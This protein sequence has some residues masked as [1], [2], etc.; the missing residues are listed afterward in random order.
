LHWKRWNELVKDMVKEN[1]EAVYK[2]GRVILPPE[3]RDTI[4]SEIKDYP[5]L[6]KYE[7]HKKLDVIG[8]YVDSE[9]RKYYS[10]P[11][12]IPCVYLCGDNSEVHRWGVELEENDFFK[13]VDKLRELSAQKAIYHTVVGVK[14][15][16]LHRLHKIYNLVRRKRGQ[17]EI[18]FSLFNIKP[19]TDIRERFYKYLREINEKTKQEGIEFRIL[20]SQLDELLSAIEEQAGK[21]D[22]N[23]N[24]FLRVLGTVCKDVFIGPRNILLDISGFCNLDC[25]YCRRFSFWNKEYWGGTNLD[26]RR[27]LDLEVIKN[28]LF[29][30]KEMGTETVLLVGGGEPTLHPDFLKII[31]FIEE[32]GMTYNFSTNG[33]LLDLYN[34]HLIDC[35]CKDVTVSLSFSSKA[36]F[37]QI[38]PNSNFKDMRRIEKGVQ[39]LANLRRQQQAT[40]PSITALYAI[41]K[42][43]YKEI[44]KMAIHAKRLGADKIWYQLVHLEGFSRENLYM[45]REDMGNV[46]GLLRKAEELCKQIGLDFCSFI[47]FEIKHYDDRKGDWSK[48]GLLRQGCFVGW[49]FTFVH[50]RKEVFMCCGAKTIGILDGKGRGLRDLWFSDVYRR[51]RNDGLIMHRENPLTIYGQLLYNAYCDSC[52]N[53]DQNKMMINMLQENRLDKFVER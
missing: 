32:L 13:Q 42:Y 8:K 47:D 49:H 5:A 23:E 20:D 38:R 26:L 51:Y 24:N 50:L 15:T 11:A 19:L 3:I 17:Q 22:F 2:P 39:Q 9:E 16:N 33:V 41:C 45:D 34:K 35:G 28:V 14:R 36:S 40:S 29:E 27:F 37:K 18:E 30:A 21:A 52:D 10:H 46:R 53:H 25:I 12:D 4:S 31:S 43:N 6:I 48:G 7:Q 44:T 1:E